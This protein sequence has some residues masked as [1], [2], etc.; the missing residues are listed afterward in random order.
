[1]RLEFAIEEVEVSPERAVP[2]G[3]I[4][5]E[6][7]TNSLRHAFDG[8]G[9]VIEVKMDFRADHFN[10]G[11]PRACHPVCGDH[12]AL[13]GDALRRDLGRQRP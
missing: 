11:G 10:G 8:Q 5:N 4:L 13:W 9:G 3:L 12:E 7:V 6:F 1:V 2:L